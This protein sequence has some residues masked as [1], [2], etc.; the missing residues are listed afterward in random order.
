[1]NPYHYYCWSSYY[2]S[3][4]SYEYYVRMIIELNNYKVLVL[5]LYGVHNYSNYYYV[6]TMVHSSICYC[7]ECHVRYIVGGTIPSSFHN[8][9]TY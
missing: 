3:T 2:V 9:M 4:E 6:H 1:M 7:T 8:G 5:L